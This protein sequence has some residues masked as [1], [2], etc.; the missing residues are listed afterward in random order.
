MAR[1]MLERD[2]GQTE[3]HCDGTGCDEVLARSTGK[4]SVY[5]HDEFDVMVDDAKNAGWV[6]RHR[7]GQW[8]H[9]CS[10]DCAS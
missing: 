7:Q 4:G 2:A 8:R 3:M 10:P 5:S 6:I 1:N 9:Y